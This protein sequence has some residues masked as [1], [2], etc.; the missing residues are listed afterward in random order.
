MWTGAEIVQ[1]DASKRDVV[2]LEQVR[3][4][5]QLPLRVFAARL[6]HP[7]AALAVARH[8]LISFCASMSSLAFRGTVAVIVEHEPAGASL[9]SGPD[10]PKTRR[11]SW[12][13][14]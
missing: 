4:V 3:R 1:R 10:A 14:W 9:L 8:A 13:K 11:P 2:R 12:H 5:P 7:E 6:A